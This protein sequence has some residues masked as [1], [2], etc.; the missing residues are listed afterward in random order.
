MEESC[1]QGTFLRAITEDGRELRRRRIGDPAALLPPGLKATEQAQPEEHLNFST[2]SLCDTVS[3]GMTKAAVS[4]LAQSR[5]IRLAQK[6]H[7]SDSWVFEEQ[8]FRCNILFD[9]AGAVVKKEK[10][11][12]TD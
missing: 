2:H 8:S 4:K 7:E 6:E 11:I 9:K 1:P 5:D 10:T 3:S 12:I